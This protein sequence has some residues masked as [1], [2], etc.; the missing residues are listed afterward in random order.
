M[1]R[2]NGSWDL[3]SGFEKLIKERSQFVIVFRKEFDC[4][5][6]G[7]DD[8]LLFA[9]LVF[10]G[11]DQLIP[12][13]ESF[14][15]LWHE[16]FYPAFYKEYTRIPGKRRILRKRGTGILTV[17]NFPAKT[18]GNRNWRVL[19]KKSI[20][21]CRIMLWKLS[22]KNYGHRDDQHIFRVRYPLSTK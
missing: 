2:R 13:G 14:C 8:S 15:I 1:F 9:N 3:L 19:G 18:Q 10:Q 22:R 4:L 16:T 5:F 20:V 11:G 6:L 17:D 21:F 7:L 12:A